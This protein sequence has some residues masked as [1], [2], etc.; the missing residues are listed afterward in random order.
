MENAEVLKAF[1][2]KRKNERIAELDEQTVMDR[3]QKTNVFIAS[4]SILVLVDFALESLLP[5]F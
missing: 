5:N 4:F 3:S 2:R 1:L